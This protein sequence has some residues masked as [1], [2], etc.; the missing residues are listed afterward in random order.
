MVLA[1]GAP[2]RPF[3]PALR[4]RSGDHTAAGVSCP[5]GKVTLASWTEADRVAG[6]QR[7]R[8]RTVT[9][10]RCGMCGRYHT[11]SSQGPS[12][13]DHKSKIRAIRR[14]EER[15]RWWE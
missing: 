13:R 9:P 6:Q 12:N 11:G 1:P 14:A 8:G 4:Q 10:Y 15:E 3:P 7:R 2:A 5:S